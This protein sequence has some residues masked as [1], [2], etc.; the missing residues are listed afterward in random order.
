MGNL[1]SLFHMGN[2]L[3][4]AILWLLLIAIPII[5]N[6]IVSK[7]FER[8]AFQKGH[9][10]SVHA[11]AMCF[12]LGAIGYIYVLALPDLRR[13]QRETEMLILLR[14]KNAQQP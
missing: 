1:A 14:E 9:T 10:T 4:A 2:I 8:I 11:F 12:W 13:E 3:L 7:K 6:C 5:I